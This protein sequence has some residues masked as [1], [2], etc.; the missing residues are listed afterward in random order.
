MDNIPSTSNLRALAN[1]SLEE[2]NNVI[3]ALQIHHMRKKEMEILEL[4]VVLLDNSD[5]KSRLVKLLAERSKQ[6][7]E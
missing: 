6:L 7:Y 3:N 5:F 4:R 2:Q 1:Q